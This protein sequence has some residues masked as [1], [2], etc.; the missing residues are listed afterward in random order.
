LQPGTHSSPPLKGIRAAEVTKAYGTVVANE[1]VDF[2]AHGGE[3]HAL[4]GE[5]GAGKSTLARVL[6]GLTRPDGGVIFIDGARVELRS[7][8][9]ALARGVG[10]VPQH[11]ALIEELTLVDNCLYGFRSSDSWVLPRK[12]VAAELTAKSHAL[13]FD[14]DPVA[15]VAQLTLGQRQRGE[16]LRLLRRDVQTLILDEPTDVLSPQESDSLFRTLRELAAEGRCIVYITHRLP[17]VLGVA[18]QI[19][20]LRDGHVAGSAAGAEI[21]EPRLLKWML[22]REYEGLRGR[23]D[24]SANDVDRRTPAIFVKGLSTHVG[25]GRRDVH[26]VTVT[27]GRGEILGIAGVDGNGQD[28]LAEGIA[29]SAPA[30]GLVEVA[31]RDVSGLDAAERHAAGVS[32]VPADRNR[33]GLV[34]DLSV[35]ENLA[36]RYL[37]SRGGG[38]LVDHR[39]MRK[40]ARELV[41]EYDIR[42]RSTQMPVSQL[43]GGNQQ[44]VVL[45]RELCGDPAVIVAVQPTRGL[46]VGARDAVHRVLL[47]HAG[48]GAGIILISSELDEI[49]RLSDRI[50]VMVMGALV[51]QYDGPDFDLEA[52]G[53]SMTAGAGQRAADS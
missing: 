9:D 36:L 15:P 29:G 33:E 46:D 4:L 49:L 24:T 31:G 6:A 13:G 48:R 38:R 22:G 25:T 1:K 51:A 53:R 34:P 42:C 41:A 32:H 39:W 16:I 35:A 45:A 50:A 21:D 19:T 47:D 43:S 23:R 2:E 7:S 10:L 26:E 27:V 18:D 14:V 12:R 8:R 28:E 20:V 37:T 52:V 30:S 44:K 5:N 40:R 3:L 17:D 11:P